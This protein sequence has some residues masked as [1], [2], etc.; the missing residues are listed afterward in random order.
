M[1]ALQLIQTSFSLN[2]D[3][4]E[5]IRQQNVSFARLKFIEW[6]SALTTALHILLYLI[7]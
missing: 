1:G 7:Q 6:R 2:R 5:N 3:G 4:Q